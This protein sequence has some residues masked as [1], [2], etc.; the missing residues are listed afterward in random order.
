MTSNRILQYRCMCI[1][2]SLPQTHLFLNFCHCPPP[3]A[4]NLSAPASLTLTQDAAA[5]DVGVGQQQQQDEGRVQP[6]M[7]G[8]LQLAESAFVAPGQEPSFESPED[9]HVTMPQASCGT[10]AAYDKL[11]RGNVRQMSVRRHRSSI[12]LRVPPPGP[13]DFLAAPASSSRVPLLSNSGSSE[14]DSSELPRPGSGNSGGALWDRIGSGSAPRRPSSLRA[15]EQ[16]SG[17]RRRGSTV[18][19]TDHSKLSNQHECVTI[20]FSDLIGFSTWA[21]ELPPETVMATLNDLYTRLDDIILEE[22]PGV[23]K[24]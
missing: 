20:F 2:L 12:N 8:T 11:T 7:P 1:E 6:D 15:S 3:K 16:S 14:L 22:M 23:Y 18:L 4:S 24:V 9:L 21:H 5:V 19:M 10:K 17:L 13:A